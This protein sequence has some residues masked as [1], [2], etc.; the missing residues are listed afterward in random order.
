M[1]N[2]LRQLMLIQ[3][4]DDLVKQEESQHNKL[5]CATEFTLFRAQCL[6]K[7]LNLL[8]GT[9]Q[10]TMSLTEHSW[11]LLSESLPLTGVVIMLSCRC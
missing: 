4:V 6:Y 9:W 1:S 7:I 2:Q 11:R 10:K 5:I 8:P 3:H